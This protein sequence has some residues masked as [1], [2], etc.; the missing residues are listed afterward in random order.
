MGDFSA[1]VG[2][3]KSLTRAFIMKVLVLFS[4]LSLGWAAPAAEAD[5]EADPEADPL[6]YGHHGVVP[7][8]HHPVVYH[9][10]NCTTV[11]EVLTHKVCTPKVET[12][13]HCSDGTYDVTEGEPVKV[14]KREAEPEAEAD[15]Q[16]LYGHGLPVLPYHHTAVE[17]KEHWVEHT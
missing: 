12:T 9:V 6:L 10:P 17:M 4:L 11:D 7:Y 16:L 8:V 15:P 13:K 1:I 3:G 14:V 2:C 5:A